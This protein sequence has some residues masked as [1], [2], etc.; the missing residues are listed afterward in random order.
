MSDDFYRAAAES[1]L[2]ATKNPKCQP[3]PLPLDQYDQWRNMVL[4]FDPKDM[5]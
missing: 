2:R 1:A 5:L 3:L 4:N